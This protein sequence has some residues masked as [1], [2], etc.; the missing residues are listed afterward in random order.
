[1]KYQQPYGV[2]DPNAAYV[3]G[4]P[5]TGTMGSIPP[6]AS[7][8]HPQ[9]ELHNYITASSLVPSTADLFQ[10]AKSVQCGRVMFG[11]DS[12]AINILSISLSP[13]PDVLTDGMCIRARINHANTGPVV[14]QVNAFGGKQIVHPDQ[15][16]MQPGELQAGMYCEFLYDQP[17]DT[18]QLVGA[19]S[20]GQ[21]I[22]LAPRDFYVNGNTGVDTNDGLTA[23]T[24]FRTIQKACDMSGAINTNGWN[25]E[26]HIADYANYAN[27][28]LP[29]ITG[30]GSI[31]LTGNVTS[32]QNVVVTSTLASTP[33]L[34]V[35]FSAG[36]FYFRG[37]KV[38]S[39]LDCGIRVFPNSTLHM[40]DMDFGPC[41]Q[42]HYQSFGGH[43]GVA[44]I[45]E[46][47]QGGLP[48]V[49]RVYV[50]GNAQYHA[51]ASNGAFFDHHGPDLIFRAAYGVSY[52]AQA[53]NCAINAIYYNNVTGG[54][55]AGGTKYIAA[56][57][58]VVSTSGRGVNYLPGTVAGFLQ[59]GGQYT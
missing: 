26:I 41:A 37:L 30:S 57:N 11:V 47:Q 51:L 4:N 18:F 5:S 6:A 8:E 15:S 12:G 25:I 50:S 7:I 54:P 32:P 14:L 24:P 45:L 36:N 3:N 10:V 31:F 59:T 29:V 2:S 27:A 46:Y 23:A 53:D 20:S 55:A 28:T 13:V 38:Q 9:R 21:K 58:G 16:K 40:N 48:Q 52:W 1:M 19:V 49:P 44:G 42:A 35:G 34:Y 33:A 43:I 22:L 39:V 56:S 17:H